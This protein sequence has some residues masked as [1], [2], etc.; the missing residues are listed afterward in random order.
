MAQNRDWVVH[1]EEFAL[2]FLVKAVHDRHGDDENGEPYAHAREREQSG[3]RDERL[4]AVKTQIFEQQ[5]ADQAKAPLF[6]P[7]LPWQ[8]LYFLPLPHGHGSLRPTFLTCSLFWVVSAGFKFELLLVKFRLILAY[9]FFEMREPLV[10]GRGI[11]Q[12]PRIA[13][14]DTLSNISVDFLVI[15]TWV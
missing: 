5:I 10:V 3:E 13:N 7:L 9:V 14:S 11:D 4:R 2:K 15:M 12:I 8:S 6:G 1:R